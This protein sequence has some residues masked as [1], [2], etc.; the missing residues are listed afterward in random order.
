MHPAIS[1]SSVFSH[2]HIQV[3]LMS[4]HFAAFVAHKRPFLASVGVI[5]QT[6]FPVKRFVTIRTSKWLFSYVFYHVPIQMF[7]N[8]EHS[9]AFMANE[10]HLV[11]VNADVF[12]QTTF[13]TKRFITIR[14][15]EWFISKVNFHMRIKVTFMPERFGTHLTNKR[16]LTRVS[17]NMPFENKFQ[18][19][20][21]VTRRTNKRLFSSVM[22]SSMPSQSTFMAEC[23]R[24]FVVNLIHNVYF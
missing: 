10:R 8:L 2:V 7:F 13:M 23:F 3:I 11:L 21:L 14:T 20:R 6:C 18:C 15:S 16:R 1:F 22:S 12:K 5:F 9:A 19:K 24:T 4:E 17:S